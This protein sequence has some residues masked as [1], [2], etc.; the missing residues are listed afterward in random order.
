[1]SSKCTKSPHPRA[2]LLSDL[3]EE[4]KNAINAPLLPSATEIHPE[5]TL[6]EENAE[7][8]MLDP[9]SRENP[10]FKD[11]VKVLIDWINSE[12]EEE[13]I[14]VKD[15]EEDCYDG[16]VL[17]KLF[18][19]LSGRKLNVAEVTQSEIGQKQKLQTVLEAVNNTLRPH[20]WTLEWSVDS[21]H[22]KNLVAIVYLLVALAMHFQAPIRLPEHVTVQVVV[23]KVRVQS[24]CRI[25][26]S[27]EERDAFDTL[28]DHAPDKLNVVKTSLITFVN[29][30]LNK[31]NL[32][33][34][35]LESQFADGVYLILLMGLLEDYFVPLYNFFLTP[36]SFEQKVHNVAFA[37]E[38]MQDGGLKKPKARP[39]DV[40]N[41]NL[42]STLRVLYNL[43]TNYKN[44]D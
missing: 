36:E 18:E 38:L 6:L 21:I 37:F 13:R 5:D 16:Q 41:L 9:T 17:Q 34:T 23:V 15:L 44:S 14:I 28:L 24:A 43:F 11:L 40:V 19:K 29:K 33:V 25:T 35:E 22:S 2:D 4:G 20:G 39:E 30:H 32:E 42:K 26:E 10:K 7:R 31:L 27:T 8:I 12:L 3:H 1:G